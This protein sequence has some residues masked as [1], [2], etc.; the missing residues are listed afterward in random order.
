MLSRKHLDTEY[1]GQRPQTTFTY[2]LKNI[3]LI[4]QTVIQIKPDLGLERFWKA[5]HDLEA[6]REQWK[7]SSIKD[8]QGG[9]L[10]L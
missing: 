6:N 4:E 3:K 8:L 1:W 5:V 10:R 2:T 7:R 9:F